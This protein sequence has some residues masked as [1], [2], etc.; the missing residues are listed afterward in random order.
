MNLPPTLNR[1][2][3]EWRIRFQ[4]R[5]NIMEFDGGM[6]EQDARTAAE[7]DVRKQYARENTSSQL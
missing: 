2:P 3:L 1:W 5:W 4:E 6:S 7:V